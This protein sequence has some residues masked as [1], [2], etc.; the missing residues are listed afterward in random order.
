MQT[1]EEKQPVD[2]ASHSRAHTEP[3][4]QNRKSA[5]RKRGTRDQSKCSGNKRKNPQTKPK[6]E[7]VPPCRDNRFNPFEDAVLNSGSDQI[8]SF[9]AAA[10]PAFNLSVYAPEYADCNA[11]DDD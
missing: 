3:T 2:G 9:C 10:A 4:A 6:E 5:K 7:L 8:V 1:P 11:N